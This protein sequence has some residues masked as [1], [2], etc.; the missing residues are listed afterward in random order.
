VPVVRVDV[1]SNELTARQCDYRGAELFQETDALA[2]AKDAAAARG[3]NLVL[4][5]GDTLSASPDEDTA[6][7]VCMTHYAQVVYVS[8]EGGVRS[9]V[10]AESV[11]IDDR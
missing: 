5:F 3:A 1:R 9:R 7:P 8:C 6:R 4:A 2:D 11:V 10:L